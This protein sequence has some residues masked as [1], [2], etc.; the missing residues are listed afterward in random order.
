MQKDDGNSL[1]SS[2]LSF[3]DLKQVNQ[4]GIEFGAQESCNPFWDVLSGNVLRMRWKKPSSH[5]SNRVTIRS[6]TLPTPVSQSFSWLHF[7]T[8]S[9]YTARDSK[10]G[11]AGVGQPLNLNPPASLKLVQVGLQ[12][13]H[14]KNDAFSGPRRA[15]GDSRA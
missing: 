3:E 9:M 15:F 7:V 5:T 1:I 2:K 10:I 13:P 14:P 4:H 11:S 12:R 8:D 6:I